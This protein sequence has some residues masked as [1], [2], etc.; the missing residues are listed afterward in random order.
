M[1]N[2]NG[3]TGSDK[4]KVLEDVANY[5]LI[6]SKISQWTKVTVGVYVKD[7]DSIT[8]NLLGVDAILQLK[9]LKVKFVG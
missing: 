7:V 3:V 2:V 6:D 1:A 4:L 5:V 8:F 9:R